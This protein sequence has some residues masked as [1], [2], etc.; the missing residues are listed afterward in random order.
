MARYRKRGRYRSRNSR[1][2]GH[3]RALQHIREAEGLSRELGGTD[4]DV[5]NYFFSLN[6]NQFGVILDKY[7]MK[8]G[9]PAREYAEKTFLKWKNRRVH[10]SG[11]VAERLFNLLPPI[12]PLPTKFQLTESLWHHVGPSSSKTYYIGLNADLDEL[13]QIIKKHLEEVVIHYK[14]PDSLEKRFS[15][16]SQGNVDIKQ[17]LLNH[18]RQQ[19]KKLLSVVLETKL[20]LLISHLERA[21]GELTTHVMQA[22]NVGKHEV[23]VLI[24]ENINGITDVAPAGLDGNGHFNWVW[25]VI[26]VGVLLWLLKI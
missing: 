7:E 23:K 6:R 2:Y 22:L 4:E 16:L 8:Y 20:P 25:W 3:E 5:K 11:T 13:D 12:M 26:G 14:I 24:K 15:W 18:L 9:T 1:S 17:Q 10:M 21:E 19:E